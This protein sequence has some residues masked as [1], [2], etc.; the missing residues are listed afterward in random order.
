MKKGYL[1]LSIIMLGFCFTGCTG[2]SSNVSQKPAGSG[3]GRMIVCEGYDESEMGVE[4]LRG[5][6][7]EGKSD[8]DAFG[9]IDR[10]LQAAIENKELTAIPEGDYIDVNRDGIGEK[11]SLSVMGTDYCLTIGESE[12]R[13]VRSDVSGTVSAAKVNNGN[14][15]E[16]IFIFVTSDNEVEDFTDIYYYEEGMIRSAGRIPICAA[17]LQ[18]NE[19]GLIGKK[20]AETVQTWFRPA[21]YIFSSDYS[22]GAEK[23]DQLPSLP[24]RIVELPSGLYPMGTTVQL[25]KDLEVYNTADENG[26]PIQLKKGMYLCLTGGDD[27]QWL[28]VSLPFQPLKPL[29]LENGTNVTGGWLRLSPAN[30]LAVQSRD[31][32][33]DCMDLFEGLSNAG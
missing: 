20:R 8:P 32:E 6:Q 28:Y 4:Y 7:V 15:N 13:E 25:K 19:F 33:I 21:Q 23:G 5:P 16:T 18:V 10:E 9:K 11:I 27:Q 12:V 2:E 31:G 24:M 22:G 30:S 17:E 14:G 1:L 26:I 29:R 3:D